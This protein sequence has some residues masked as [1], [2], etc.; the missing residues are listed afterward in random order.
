MAVS[1]TRLTRTSKQRRKKCDEEKPICR[2]CRDEEFI[3]D[4]YADPSAA[5][6]GST[7]EAK[8]CVDAVIHQHCRRMLEQRTFPGDPA[9]LYFHQH[10]FTH[11]IP[12]LMD[13]PHSRAFW[14][15]TVIA[16]L[17]HASFIQP[18]VAALGAAHWVFISGFS[19]HQ[20]QDFISGQYSQ[21]ISYM[22]PHMVPGRSPIFSHIMTCC[23]L[24]VCLESLRGN[25]SVALRHMESGSRLLLEHL[26]PQTESDPGLHRLALIF[27][28]LGNQAGLFSESRVIPDPA[29]HRSS[30]DQDSVTFAE[31]LTTMAEADE[32][33]DKLDNY[34]NNMIWT[35]HSNCL[36]YAGGRCW[37]PYGC[38]CRGCLE[39]KAFELRVKSF[40]SRLQPLVAGLSG[41]PQEQQS[42]LRLRLL[43]KVWQ[44]TV[45]D[46]SRDHAQED[47]DQLKTTV[48]NDLLEL[49]ER[50]LTLTA[51]RPTYS[52]A[53]DTIPT[54]ITVFDICRD[55]ASKRRIIQLLRAYPRT[56]IIFNSDNVAA[57][58]EHHMSQ[59]HVGGHN[60][61]NCASVD[62]SRWPNALLDFVPRDAIG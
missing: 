13:V 41:H 31:A 42:L 12:E 25:Q 52:L 60:S 18:A 3:C 29:P 16:S 50:I 24:F 32:V 48:S 15:E 21:A 8:L 57:Y 20:V 59:M 54:L 51:L 58:L 35:E 17:Q 45:H 37:C 56:E 34:Y 4:G 33:L 10:F 6:L 49:A 39:W 14:N 7:D 43:N 27:H 36:H 46:G 26:D 5:G 22:A 2:R 1:N 11:T 9:V 23:L 30:F 61:E 55:P 19:H 47:S 44:W 62:L 28:T 38:E 53:A 40:D